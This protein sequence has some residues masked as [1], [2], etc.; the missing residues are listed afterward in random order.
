MADQAIPTNS[1][2]HAESHGFDEIASSRR[3]GFWVYLMS[4]SVLFATLF[5]TYA[6]LG[7]NYAGG[8]TP[9]QVYHLGG[10]IA[11]T[12][13]VLTST[14]TMGLTVLFMVRERRSQMLWT[15]AVTFALGAAVVVLQ[16]VGFASMI[17]AGAGLDR[18]AFLSSYFA[19]VGTHSAHIVVGLLWM[20]IMFFKIAA[21]GLT[22]E[23]ASRVMLMSMFWYF[24]TI[25]WICVVTIVYLMGVT[26]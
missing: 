13:L 19:L 1:S 9:R 21:Q 23:N 14:F 4:D 17:R 20:A 22:N 5:A 6:V 16:I 10:V 11:E 25:V 8:P 7:H 3:L 18:S 12:A 26:P 2:G 15:L 24:I